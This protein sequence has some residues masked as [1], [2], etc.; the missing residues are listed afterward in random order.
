MSYDVYK[1]V[2]LENECDQEI[3]RGLDGRSFG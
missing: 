1:V 2:R 3:P